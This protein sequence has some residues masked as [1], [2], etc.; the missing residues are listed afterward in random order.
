[1]NPSDL[2]DLPIHLPNQETPVP[3]SNDAPILEEEP[4]NKDPTFI[5]GTNII[6]RTDEDIAQWI[7]ERKR[8]WPTKQNI[9]EKKRK[10]QS[11]PEEPPSSSS[12]S[13]NVC[14][15]FARNRKCRYGNKCKNLHQTGSNH[16]SNSSSTKVING[17]T[18][19]I[20]QRYKNELPPDIH[21][22]LYK[23]LVQRDLYENENDLVLD[24]VQYLDSKGVIDHLVSAS[25]S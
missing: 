4:T 23:K 3:E 10:L 24:F 8:H 16:T 19:S 15:F 21:L 6:L 2:A 17:L 14:R 20:P 22:S 11:T 13:K 7:A 12:S 18:V 9:E 5:E 1:M 25:P